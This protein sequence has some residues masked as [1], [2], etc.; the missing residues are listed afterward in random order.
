MASMSWLVLLRWQF[1]GENKTAFIID[2]KNQSE[3]EERLHTILPLTF[4]RAAN[5][6]IAIA[7]ARTLLATSLTSNKELNSADEPLDDA[8]HGT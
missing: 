8:S 2:A 1:R 5:F 4:F 7:P 3:A 6:E